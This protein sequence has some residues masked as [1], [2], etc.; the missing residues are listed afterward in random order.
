MNVCKCNMPINQCNLT[1][2]DF[3][4]LSVEGNLIRTEMRSR[5]E[6]VEICN[7]TNYFPSSDFELDS[8]NV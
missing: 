3:N 1:S 8:E 7:F 4:V 2:S 6:N 5:A